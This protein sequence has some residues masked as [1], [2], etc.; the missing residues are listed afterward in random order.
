MKLKITFLGKKFEELREKIK[1]NEKEK[2]AFL[3]CNR[4]EFNSRIKLIPD[5]IILAKNSDYSAVSA[6]FYQLKRTFVKKVI[7]QALEEE[8]DIIQVHSHPFNPAKYSSVD[9]NSELEFMNYLFEKIENMYHA[10]IVFSKDAQTLDSWFFNPKTRNLQKT[11]K[12]LVVYPEKFVLYLPQEEKENVS[13]SQIQDRTIRA[14]GKQAVK[15]FSKIDV[16]IIGASGIGG[17]LAEILART[18]FKNLIIC[19]P[20]KIELSNLNRLQ[21]AGIKDENKNKAIFYKNYLDSLIPNLNIKAI[22]KSF[23]LPEVQMQFAL[24]DIIFSCVDSGAVHSINRL[25]LANLC[26]LF[27]LNSGINVEN[28]KI[29]FI[30]GH[31][32]SVIPG[33]NVCINCLGVFDHL[34][35]QFLNPSAQQREIQQGYVQGANLPEP[36]VYFLNSIIASLGFWQMIKYILGIKQPELKI[37]YNALQNKI[38][39]SE[40][41]ETKGCLVCKDSGFLAQANK[42]PLLIPETNQIY[43]KILNSLENENSGIIL[44]KEIIPTQKEQKNES[45]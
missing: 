42:V 16:G 14:F 15:I 28:E 7:T 24:V 44:P 40:I 36:Q 31:I 2:F 1:F 8:K 35:Y 11:E 38:V 19:D 39:S 10:S 25:A 27:V 30:G 34:L 29:N 13:F 4:S 43:Q 12:I 22:P 23:F 33:N 26:P 32:Y 21:G 6:G 3:L 45:S 18:G 5:K 37:Y 9:R 20:D 17:P 41:E